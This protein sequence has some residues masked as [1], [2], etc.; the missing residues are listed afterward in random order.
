MNKIM[1]AQDRKITDEWIE[2]IEK[3]MKSIPVNESLWRAFNLGRR[4]PFPPAGTKD[5]EDVMKAFN[6]I[7][8]EHMIEWDLEKFK[9]DHPT[10]L[11]TI[12]LTLIHFRNKR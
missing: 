2:N 5:E 9:K 3:S 10:L 6:E 1:N 4:F 8:K 7:A 12:Y 11:K